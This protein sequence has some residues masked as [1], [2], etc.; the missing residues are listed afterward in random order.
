MESKPDFFEINRSMVKQAADCF[1]DAIKDL[2][3]KMNSAVK[4][5]EADY[6]KGYALFVRQ[7]ERELH[8]LV[9]KLN[10]RNT[11]SALKDEIIFGLKT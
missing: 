5:Q 3:Q 10:D 2:D 1:D 4:A 8:E 7:K 11:N 6:L 9:S